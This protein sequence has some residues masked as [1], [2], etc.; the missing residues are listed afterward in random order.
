MSTAQAANLRIL[1]NGIEFYISVRDRE[2]V[3]TLK[4][5]LNAAIA[6]I[7]WGE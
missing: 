3:R 6:D 4:G 7:A 2:M 5:R 1:R